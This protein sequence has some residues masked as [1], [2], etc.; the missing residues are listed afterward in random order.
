M[1]GSKNGLDE[2][3]SSAEKP[4]RDLE[5]SLEA[6]KRMFAAAR[7]ILDGTRDADRADA[8]KTGAEPESPRVSGTPD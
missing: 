6:T 1:N 3:V 2:R 7:A 5:R 4:L 8:G